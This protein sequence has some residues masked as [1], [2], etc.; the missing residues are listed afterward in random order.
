MGSRIGFDTEKNLLDLGAVHDCVGVA[1]N[2]FPVEVDHDQPIHNLEKAVHDVLDHD[3]GDAA[4]MNV[5]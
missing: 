3:D 2:D 1:I 5:T 4:G